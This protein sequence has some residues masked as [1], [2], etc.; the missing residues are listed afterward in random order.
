MT[1]RPERYVEYLL[2]FLCSWSLAG[3]AM[4]PPSTYVS[5]MYPVSYARYLKGTRDWKLY[6][7]SAI[8]P[9]VYSDADYAGRCRDDFNSTSG[10]ITYGGARTGNGLYIISP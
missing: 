8:S 1:G 5:A 7:G 6:R 3:L 2:Y 9:G 10:F 4:I